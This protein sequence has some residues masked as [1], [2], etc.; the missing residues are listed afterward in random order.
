M[1]DPRP[2]CV[3]MMLV[4]PVGWCVQQVTC[5]W[6]VVTCRPQSRYP[7]IL[8]DYNSLAVRLGKWRSVLMSFVFLFTLKPIYVVLTLSQHTIH[9]TVMT[10]YTIEITSYSIPWCVSYYHVHHLCKLMRVYYILII[11]VWNFCCTGHFTPFCSLVLIPNDVINSIHKCSMSVSYTLL[12][13]AVWSGD[14][15]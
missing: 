14:I 3:T 5:V 10:Y 6:V 13:V 7:S 9:L 11:V 8:E 2:C 1:A 15:I 12:I 4:W